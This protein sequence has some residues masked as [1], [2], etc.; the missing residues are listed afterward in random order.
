MCL[1]FCFLVG[2]ALFLIVDL[3]RFVTIKFYTTE[4]LKLNLNTLLKIQLNR[5]IALKV[6]WI[7]R[8]GEIIGQIWGLSLS[9][10]PF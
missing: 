10:V 9:T 1:K 7:R 6:Q 4:K 8:V 2:R 3:L 5:N